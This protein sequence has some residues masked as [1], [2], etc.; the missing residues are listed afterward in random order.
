MSDNS[1]E[2]NPN[3]DEP[4][5]ME[6]SDPGGCIFHADVASAIESR[7]YERLIKLTVAIGLYEQDF[8]CGQEVL[9]K[10]AHC[11]DPTVRGNAVLSFG[12]FARRFG[13]LD[14]V[15]IQPLIEVALIDIDWHVSGQA[16]AAASD[17]EHFL[18]W[19]IRRPPRMT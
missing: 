14:V 6:Y 16:Y 5:A 18:G 7:D 12:H 9:I 13:Q 2:S 3:E 4:S 1:I 17:V 11:E 10:L 8:E 15:R 19:K